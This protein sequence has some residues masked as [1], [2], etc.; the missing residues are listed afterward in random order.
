MDR[1]MPKL[2]DHVTE[3]V[4]NVIEITKALD[5]ISPVENEIVDVLLA[6]FDATDIFEE[7]SKVLV[8]IARMK[9]YKIIRERFPDII[10]SYLIAI[11]TANILNKNP[12]FKIDEVICNEILD[13]KLVTIL[14]QLNFSEIIPGNDKIC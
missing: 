3:R 7:S 14:G 13:S 10:Q 12:D 8:K 11:V 4:M 6:C 2:I 9:H 1:E 5:E